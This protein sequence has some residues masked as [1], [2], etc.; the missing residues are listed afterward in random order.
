VTPSGVVKSKK[1]SAA[2]GLPLA[3]SGG[4]VDLM[5]FGTHATIN[6]YNAT[7]LAQL[8]SRKISNNAENIAGDS[9]GLVVEVQVCGKKC[10]PPTF[11][12]LNA[13][14]GAVSGTIKLPGAAILLPGP[15]AGV[16]EVNH[17]FKGSM[18]L[19]RLS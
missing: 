17:G 15:S 5:L 2:V 9:L 4:R 16:I 1:I 19:Q 6:T 12:K 8:S 11:S 3:L 7:T 13:G 18:T 10:S 14:T